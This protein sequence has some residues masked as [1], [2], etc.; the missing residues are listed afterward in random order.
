MI[1]CGND[2]MDKCGVIRDRGHGAALVETNA[3]ILL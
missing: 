1:Y 2:F 3:S